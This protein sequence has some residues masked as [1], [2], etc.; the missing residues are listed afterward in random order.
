[1]A[2]LSHYTRSTIVDGYEYSQ[3][4]PEILTQNKINQATVRMENNHPVRDSAVSSILQDPFRGGVATLI[5]NGQHSNRSARPSS[6]LINRA[7]SFQTD[8]QRVS[9]QLSSSPLLFYFHIQS[10]RSNQGYQ[11]ITLTDLLNSFLSPLVLS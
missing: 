4:F 1:M 3:S 9:T 11:S 8:P 10:N 6:L 2:R 5:F 7:N